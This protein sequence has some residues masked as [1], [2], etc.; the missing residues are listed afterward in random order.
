MLVVKINIK[1]LDH[2]LGFWFLFELLVVLLLL[3]GANPV[4]VT[5][6]VGDLLIAAVDTTSITA[7]WILYT[8]GTAPHLQVSASS[9]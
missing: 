8:L 3:V 9:G 6:L 5:R 1:L 7:G 4:Q 2:Q